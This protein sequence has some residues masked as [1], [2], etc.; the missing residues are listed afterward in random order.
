MSIKTEFSLWLIAAVIVTIAVFSF[1]E[2][3][4]GWI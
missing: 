4:A 3:V 1:A 2:Q